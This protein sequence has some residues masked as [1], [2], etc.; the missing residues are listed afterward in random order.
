MWKD[1]T[2]LPNIFFQRPQPQCNPKAAEAAQLRSMFCRQILPGLVSCKLTEEFLVVWVCLGMLSHSQVDPVVFVKACRYFLLSIH[3]PA[4]LEHSYRCLF[5]LR[6]WRGEML[7]YR[8][9]DILLQISDSQMIRWTHMHR[10][11]DC[12]C[13]SSFFWKLHKNT[14]L[15]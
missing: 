14:L 8:V 12:F 6:F 10:L 3:K 2:F 15:P 7:V 11:P 5:L 4:A 13:K 9:L 1:E